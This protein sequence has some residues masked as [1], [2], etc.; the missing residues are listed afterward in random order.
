MRADA[1]RRIGGYDPTLRDRNAQ[2]CEDWAVLLMLAEHYRFV[3]VPEFLLGYRQSPT[4]MSSDRPQMWR[5]SD[6]V[7]ARHAARYPLSRQA[8]R[9]ARK[10]ALVTALQYAVDRRLHA[11][12]VRLGARMA[13]RSPRWT[14][15]I[16]THYVG[17]IGQPPEPERS[18]FDTAEGAANRQPFVIGSPDAA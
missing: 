6:L 12:V 16:L 9:T 3:A 5:S 8:L 15:K 2:G 13:L 4:N 18:P 10:T 1:L 14:Y 17:L 11:S 7:A